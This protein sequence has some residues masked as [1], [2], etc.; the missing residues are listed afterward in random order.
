LINTAV[1]LLASLAL[2]YTGFCR[3]V[4]TDVSTVLCIRVAFWLLTVAASV[5]SAAVL[6]WGYQPGWPSAALA[7]SM[8][9][10]QVA[11]SLLW[12][13]G[14]PEPYRLPSPARGPSD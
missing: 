10:V 3:L 9:V 11:S 1:Y 5:S 6:V 14:V 12:R 13:G 2:A 8:A 7:T 4:R